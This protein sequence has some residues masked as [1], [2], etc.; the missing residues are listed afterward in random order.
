MFT[1]ALLYNFLLGTS[2]INI[3][4]YTFIHG[5]HCFIVAICAIH[6]TTYPWCLCNRRIPNWLCNH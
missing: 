4:Q 3:F 2:L 5:K 6:V 1:T